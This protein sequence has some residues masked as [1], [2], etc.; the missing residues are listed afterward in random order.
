[1]QAAADA[2]EREFGPIDLWIN[3][4]M[5]SM[6]SPFMKMSPGEF[7]HIVKRTFLGQVYGT[8]CA[9][10]RMMQRDHGVI[11]QVGSSLAF[12]SIP[13]QSAYCA[14][15]HAV[16]GFTE[17]IHNELTRQKSNVRVSAVGIPPLNAAQFTST[18]NKMPRRARLAGTTVPPEVAA[19]AI[20]FAVENDHRETIVGYRTV[21]AMSGD[22][23]SHG[24]FDNLARNV[25]KQF[26]ATRHRTALS[27]LFI[28]VGVG[29]AMA[30]LVSHGAKSGRSFVRA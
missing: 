11:I 4:A 5:V 22:H 3:N 14:S 23:V 24:R 12:R 28:I 29:V 2:A 20:L 25:G 1:V 17:S 18:K 21:E 8:Y 10:Q 7:K 9:L 13:L 16:Q 6:Y 19:D 27:R 15:Q 30:L 26:W